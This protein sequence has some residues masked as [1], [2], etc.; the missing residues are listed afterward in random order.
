MGQVRGRPM[1]GS[2]L[3]WVTL[4]VGAVVALIPPSLVLTSV[5]L[6][7]TPTFLEIE[8]RLPRFPPDPYGFTR[9]DRLRWAS[10]AL[11]Y[12]LNEAGTEFLGE[13]RFADGEPVYN[14]RELRHMDDVKRLTQTAL[15]V[16]RACLA[17]AVLGL[18]VLAAR[19]GRGEVW[20]A[21]S[22]SGQL[23]MA[24]MVG[25]GLALL[26]G[27][28]FVFVG[29][30]RVF[31][32]GDSWLFHYS[33]TLIRLFPERFWQDAFLWVAGLTALEGALLWR[34]GRA[35]LRRVSGS[36]SQAEG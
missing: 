36:R 2:R 3:R 8:Y 6:L 14:A 22:L 11:D 24:L 35:R 15:L 34:I 25:L 13:L 7:L 9:E 26:L 1:P 16:W 17:A 19:A 32:E 28:S 30:H 5:R 20:R 18:V 10:I 21:L 12:L 23:T 29:F 33:D 31:F 27:F 4:A